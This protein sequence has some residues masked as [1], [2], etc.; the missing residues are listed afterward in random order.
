MDNDKRNYFWIGFGA[1]VLSVVL[2]SLF[3]K[4]MSDS[5]DPTSLLNKAAGMAEKAAPSK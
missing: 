3:D 1:F 5:H 2:L 4:V